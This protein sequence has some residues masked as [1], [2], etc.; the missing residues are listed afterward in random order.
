MK[1]CFKV[2]TLSSSVARVR[3]RAMIPMLALEE[4]GEECLH[5]SHSRLVDLS[6]VDV[7]VVVKSFHEL[8][9][10][11]ASGYATKVGRPA[12]S[13]LSNEI[14]IERHPLKL[15]LWELSL[16]LGND[17]RSRVRCR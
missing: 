8:V 15:P 16:S 13:Y 9:P 10:T 4:A 3:Y 7:L 17:Q 12:D 11:C 14:I 6:S 1:V 2:P 5:A